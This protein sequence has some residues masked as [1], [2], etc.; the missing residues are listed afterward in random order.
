MFQISDYHTILLNFWILLQRSE[1]FKEKAYCLTFQPEYRG[2][3]KYSQNLKTSKL[4]LSLHPISITLWLKASFNI[5]QTSINDELTCI[6]IADKNIF[7]LCLLVTC[8]NRLDAT[9]VLTGG[10]SKA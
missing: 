7:F 9:H 2:C 5:L 1:N 3:Q 4:T 6:F 8:M 10:F